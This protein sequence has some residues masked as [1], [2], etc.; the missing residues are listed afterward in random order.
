MLSFSSI[1]RHREDSDEMKFGIPALVD[2]HQA[3]TSLMS[4]DPGIVK[5]YGSVA[6]GVATHD[7]DMDLCVIF[8]DVD[9]QNRW[10]IQS[11]AE[12]LVLASTGFCCNVN[13]SD[14]PEW[15][16][17]INISSSFEHHI[18]SYALTL[19]ERPPL[20]V[21]W[22]KSLPCPTTNQGMAEKTLAN[23]PDQ[24]YQTV[25]HFL[26]S[27]ERDNILSTEDTDGFSRDE[28]QGRLVRAC[29]TAHVL[30]SMSLKAINH[31]TCVP[32]IS[33]LTADPRNAIMY[34]MDLA[35]T[36]KRE[37]LYLLGDVAPELMPHLREVCKDITSA[38]REPFLRYG[39]EKNAESMCTA[40]LQIAQI[41][42]KDS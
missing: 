20:E 31:A 25:N 7:S 30:I 35:P 29:V 26:Q 21:N 37:L 13:I 8:D 39:T 27:F 12:D 11:E 34:N 28:H 24:A 4:L 17:L 42:Y 33:K 38:Y 14:R 6:L 22:E 32:H 36:H 19:Y 18:N 1:G 40:A 10:R 16:A 5:V 41:G 23:L 3:S 15:N 9:Y 2:A